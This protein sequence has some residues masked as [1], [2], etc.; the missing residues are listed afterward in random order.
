[1]HLTLLLLGYILNRS[2]I[3]WIITLL[4][5]C[6]HYIHTIKKIFELK[7]LFSFSPLSFF[8]T[9]IPSCIFFCQDQ[10]EVASLSKKLR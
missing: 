3:C 8:P 7:P 4:S 10:I 9:H 6:Q 1:M 5:M 2:V